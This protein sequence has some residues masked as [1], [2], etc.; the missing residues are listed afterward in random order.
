[1]GV[2]GDCF[3]RNNH[4][5]DIG[6]CFSIGFDK[7]AYPPGFCDLQ[8][9]Y[10]V[11]YAGSNHDFSVRH[12]FHTVFYGIHSERRIGGI[13]FCLFENCENTCSNCSGSF[14][15]CLVISPWVANFIKTKTIYMYK[16]RTK[17]ETIKEAV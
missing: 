1:M 10:R 4:S 14:L 7:T 6:S 9:A 5:R 13:G 11:Y 17:T 16:Y 12:S 2:V 8:Y 15:L 3:L